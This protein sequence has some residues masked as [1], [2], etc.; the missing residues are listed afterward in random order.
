MQAGNRHQVIGAGSAHDAPM[1]RFQPTAVTIDQGNYN[2]A[3]RMLPYPCLQALPQ[4]AYYIG[5]LAMVGGSPSIDSTSGLAICSRNCRAY[6]DRLS[7]YR[8]CPSA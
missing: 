8:L 1:L 4:S 2:T 6:E 5:F 7:T 3:Q